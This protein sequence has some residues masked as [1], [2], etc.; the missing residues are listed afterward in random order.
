MFLRHTA[1][2]AA[3]A[4]AL[5]ACTACG[6]PAVP[7]QP[8]LPPPPGAPAAPG[9]APAAPGAPAVPGAAA[10]QAAHQGASA[11]AA[12]AA[13]G[14]EKG[15]EQVR[16]AAG[17]IAAGVAALD[18]QVRAAAGASGVELDDSLTA[19]QQA[20]L[21]DLQAR[22]G[23]S[24]DQAWTRAVLDVYGQLKA[25]AEAALSSPDASEDAKAAARAA[26]AKLDALTGQLRSQP[27]S[28]GG[29][30]PTTVDTGTGGQAASTGDGL[31]LVPVA[32]LAAGALLAGGAVRAARR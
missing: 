12:L 21:A 28:S 10:A 8:P 4:L 20:L 17:R 5:V 14:E 16:A 19:D 29:V 24:F 7:A 32:L 30:P 25:A 18:E 22:S 3:A 1:A 6:G 15:G 31:P 13:V 2:T 9:A 26:L 27:G 23:T 11:L